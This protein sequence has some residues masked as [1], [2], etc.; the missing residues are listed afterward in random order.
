MKK[1]INIWSFPE[2]TLESAGGKLMCYED[3]GAHEIK[4]E[5]AE[6]VGEGYASGNISDLGGYYNELLYFTNKAKSGEKIERA[7]LA[8]ASASLAFVLKEL[9]F[10]A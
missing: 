1:G 7:T 2:G 4:I 9:S 8:D 5:K 3:T 6:L 10:Q